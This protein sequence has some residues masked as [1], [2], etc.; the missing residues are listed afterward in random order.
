MVNPRT[1]PRNRAA[2]DGFGMISGDEDFETPPGVTRAERAEPPASPLSP[3]ALNMGKTPKGEP[4]RLTVSRVR[5]EAPELTRLLDDIEQSAPSGFANTIAQLRAFARKTAVGMAYHR[6]NI[7]TRW[8]RGIYNALIDPSNTPSQLCFRKLTDVDSV[9]PRGP[10]GD[11]VVSIP[12]VNGGIVV[13]GPNARGDETAVAHGVEGGI[14]GS[15]TVVADW[16]MSRVGG[17]DEPTEEERRAGRRAVVTR[18]A[19]APPR[20]RP[21]T[22]HASSFL[23]PRNPPRTTGSQRATQANNQMVPD[24]K[25]GFEKRAAQKGRTGGKGTQGTQISS[26]GGRRG[27]GG[28]GENIDISSLRRSIGEFPRAYKKEDGMVVAPKGQSEFF[29]YHDIPDV[30]GGADTL[31][32]HQYDSNGKVLTLCYPSD[33]AGKEI[34]KT[35]RIT[36]RL[37][38]GRLVAEAKKEVR[39]S[40]GNKVG[41]K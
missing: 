4:G 25:G 5:A 13:K 8:E 22:A 41:A 17:G 37:A 12:K 23:F 40:R 27:P 39:R 28:R 32:L 18:L 34:E 21:G 9:S 19:E 24:E 36:K 29:I 3:M 1:P 33:A 7:N 38:N 6:D 11:D 35:V 14:G 30:N 15:I 26:S 20:S 16:R 10:F 31:G 2:W